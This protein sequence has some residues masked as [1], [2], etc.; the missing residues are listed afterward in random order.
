MLLAALHVV[1][2][3]GGG[4]AAE[5][6]H[7]H[8]VHVHGLVQVA[9]EV[10]VPEDHVTVFWAD[11]ED[12]GVDRAVVR[13]PPVA[14]DWLLTGTPLD[15]ITRP[16][17]ELLDT[18]FPHRVQPATREALSQWLERNG[19]QMQAGDTLLVAVT[20]HGEP[21]QDLAGGTNTRV[22][23]WGESLSVAQLQADLAPVPETVRVVLWMS[24]CHS[25]GFARISY[26]RS[27]TCGAFSA[28]ADRVA[29]GCFPELAGRPDVGHFSRM[30]TGLARGG[31]LAAAHDEVL[32]E[33]DTPD[34]PH[35]AS[36]E[37]LLAALDAA[38]ERRGTSAER[39]VDNRLPGLP[40]DAPERL[41]AAR[42]ATR[43]GLGA[44]PDYGSVL[45]VIATLDDAR[46][47]L[48]AW[49]EVRRYAIDELRDHL[50]K[51]HA[52]KVGEPK[53]RAAKRRARERAVKAAERA[54]RK[55]G[56]RARLGRMQRGDVQAGDLL[57]RIE[58]QEA[59][60]IRV[61]WLY[62]RLAGPAAIEDEQAL[63]RYAD[64]RACEEAPLWAA[65]PAPDESDLAGPPYHP[66]PMAPYT[67]LAAEIDALRPGYFGVAYKDARRGGG[68]LVT[69]VLPGTPG[70]AAGLRPGDVVMAV[71]GWT[72]KRAKDLRVAAVL[73]RPGD[74]ALF[75]VKRD[76]RG[77]PQD[78]TLVVAPMPLPSRPPR[79]GEAVPDLQLTAHAD[80]RLPAIGEGA[81]VMLYFWETTCEP[82]KR[83]LPALQAYARR[84]RTEVVAITD[85]DPRTVTDFLRKSPLPFPVARD[86]GRVARRLFGVGATPTFVLVDE[87]GHLVESGVGFEGELPVR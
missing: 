64:L 15:R 54:A 29:Y 74:R 79:P 40:G 45:D 57:A 22:T 30:L 62:A 77:K 50:T 87:R 52:R 34:T 43:Y 72:L 83:A 85:E 4:E 19:P 71:D 26:A 67:R 36:D 60:A 37:V 48:D 11:G 18:R 21:D 8:L 70:A 39:L 33:D 53:G 47:A 1:V 46:H 61:A 10:G 32:F 81:R 14:G 17:P 41:V 31:V 16:G 25:G 51:K 2:L 75:S 55:G 35:L 5:N 9:A 6:H 73:A 24:Q 42:I 13:E 12:E 65:P 44:L 82:C 38:A 84:T 69:E 7:S 63:R 66:R 56:Y 80:A 58:L 49:G 86:S 20:D 78:V 27:N 76:G 68:A 28:E 23:L 59:A 3:A